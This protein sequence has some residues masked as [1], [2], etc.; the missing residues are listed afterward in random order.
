[1][2]ILH[3]IDAEVIRPVAARNGAS[4]ERDALGPPAL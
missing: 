1:M 4:P 2:G 3:P